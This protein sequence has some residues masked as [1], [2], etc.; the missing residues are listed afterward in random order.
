MVSRLAFAYVVLRCNWITSSTCSPQV[1]TGLSEVIGSWKI[2]DIWLPRIFL[3]WSGVCCS[4]SMGSFSCLNNIWPETYFA[5]GIGSNCRMDNAVT[6]LPEP[7]SPTIATI[8]PRFTVKE[9]V[10]TAVV[11]AISVTKSTL[12]SFMCRS[13]INL[14]SYFKF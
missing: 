2:I 4:I 7:D 13:K 1:N 8:S 14:L 5:G 12:R 3:S 9:I 11:V 6:D 10:F